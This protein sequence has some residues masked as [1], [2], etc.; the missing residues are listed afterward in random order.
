MNQNNI[1]AATGELFATNIFVREFCFL[2]ESLGLPRKE[3]STSLGLSLK[4]IEDPQVVISKHYIIKAYTILLEYSNDEFLGAGNTKLPRGS[5]DLMIKSATTE[6]TLLQALKAIEQVI[7]I[8]QSP[9]S[10]T[11]VIEGSF[12]HWRFHPEVKDS[13]FSLLISALCACMGH[14]VLSTLIKKEIPL[15]HA[16]FMEKKPKNLS[17]YQFLFSCPVKFKKEYCEI[18]FDIKWLKQTVKCN[19]KEVKPYLDIPLS[20]ITYSFQTLGFIRQIKDVLSAC[21]YAR[22]PTQ[23]QLAEQLGVSVRTMQRKLDSENSNYMQIKDDIRQ[24]KAV[25]YLEHTDK[26]FDEIAER[27]GFSEIASFTRAF[28]RWTGCSPSKYKN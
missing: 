21:P 12:L 22:F 11:T 26:R 24:R 25:F 3:F 4:S 13:R 6:Q 5:V 20:L 19:Y 23:T 8:T 1:S 15:E 14:K 17:D 7:R 28:I 9:V 10:S 2:A 27:C 16:Y 18:V